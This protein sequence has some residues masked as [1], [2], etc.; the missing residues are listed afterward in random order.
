[1]FFRVLYVVFFLLFSSISEHAR[2][3]ASLTN[4]NVLSLM[5]RTSTGTATS[6]GFSASAATKLPIRRPPEVT[7]AFS[8]NPGTQCA[9]VLLSKL[10]G[11]G[12]ETSFFLVNRGVRKGRSVLLRVQGSKRLVKGR[13]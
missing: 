11:E 9:P 12:V 3:L 13:A 1:M 8:S 6:R 4:P 7:L 5:G 10:G 2:F